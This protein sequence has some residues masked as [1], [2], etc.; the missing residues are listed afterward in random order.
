[1]LG[2]GSVD[3]PMLAEVYTYPEAGKT[4]VVVEAE[5][6][7]ATCGREMLGETILSSRGAI[8]VQELTLAMP[9]CLAMGDILVLKNLA[10]DT[11]LANR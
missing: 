1:M 3:L 11:K 6:T 4:E 8:E 10:P 2:N 5:V 9:D 7:E